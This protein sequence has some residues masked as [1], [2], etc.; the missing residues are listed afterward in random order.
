MNTK[1]AKGRKERTIESIHSES[2]HFTEGDPRV[3]RA[4]RTKNHALALWSSV[5][6]LADYVTQIRSGI[7]V[8]LAARERKGAAGD[9]GVLQCAHRRD[10]GV[11]GGGGNPL[12]S[13][14]AK[15]IDSP[16]H[17]SIEA[18][19]RMPLTQTMGR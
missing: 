9:G 7:F 1:F 17:D 2:I 14:A 5:Q 18:P 13:F 10:G 16:I 12:R 19:H 6:P 3:H 8:G 15:W 11:D 4:S